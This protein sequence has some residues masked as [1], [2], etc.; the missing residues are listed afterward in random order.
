[1]NI[2]EEENLAQD[3]DSIGKFTGFFLFRNLINSYNEAKESN[4]E[5]RTKIKK[6]GVIYIILAIIALLISGSCLLCSIT[7]V[8]FWGFSY[9]VML[10]IF[11]IGGV[12]I[13]ALF[14]IYSCVFAVMQVRLNRRAS[15]I[16]G[17]VFSV[18]AMVSSI[19][20]VVFMIL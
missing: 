18:L 8:E 15:G 2:R 16:I 13:S 9:V 17:I 11:I 10:L 5:D 3:K 7:G 6:Y 12:I 4:D 20:L 19:L 14:A 1:M